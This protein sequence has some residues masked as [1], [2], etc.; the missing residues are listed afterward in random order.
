MPGVTPGGGASRPNVLLTGH[1][2]PSTIGAM[3]TPLACVACSLDP[4]TTSLVLPLAQ[5]TILAAPVIL[6]AEI[7]K[8]LRAVRARRSKAGANN[9]AV[10]REDRTTPDGGADAQRR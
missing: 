1:G 8:G 2:P 6:R 3:S 9:A 5:A 7:R 4:Q 10:R